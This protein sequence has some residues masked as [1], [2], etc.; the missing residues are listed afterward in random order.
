[1]K[2]DISGLPMI[3][4]RTTDLCKIVDQMDVFSGRLIWGSDFP[5]NHWLL[6]TDWASL[7]WDVTCGRETQFKDRGWPKYGPWL[8]RDDRW[9]RQIRLQYATGIEPEV[10]QAT[11]KFLIDSGRVK[12]DKDQRLTTSTKQVTP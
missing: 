12:L 8:E 2:A 10:F 1:L 6:S 4:T 3:K 7:V 9:Y 5:L 11:E